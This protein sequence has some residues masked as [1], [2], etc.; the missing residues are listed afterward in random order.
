MRS[1]QSHLRSTKDV[2]VKEERDERK[3]NNRN[4]CC[5]GHGERSSGR[6]IR[7]AGKVLPFT[8][9]L[10]ARGSYRGGRG[11]GEGRDP[12]F[13]IESHQLE[14]VAVQLA[15]I[16][17]STNIQPIRIVLSLYGPWIKRRDPTSIIH[18]NTS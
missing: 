3:E 13:A 11:I 7:I 4:E 16:H 2:E 6:G 12:R 18:Y 9:S 15:N 1:S 14:I 17:G 5:G 8:R 10:S